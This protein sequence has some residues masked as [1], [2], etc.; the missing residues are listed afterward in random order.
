MKTKKMQRRGKL[1]GLRERK[2]EERKR[3]GGGIRRI[4]AFLCPVLSARSKSLPCGWQLPTA[5]EP[6]SKLTSGDGSWQ[7]HVPSGMSS[8][9]P[10]LHLSGTLKVQLRPWSLL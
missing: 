10:L 3:S 8:L 4:T 5:A 9:V 2:E 6:W 7:V 1:D